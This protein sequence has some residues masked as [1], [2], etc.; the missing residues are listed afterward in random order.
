MFTRNNNFYLSTSYFCQTS[1]DQRTFALQDGYMSSLV[2]R[3]WR[4]FW[5][6]WIFRCWVLRRYCRSGWISWWNTEIEMT[7]WPNMTTKYVQDLWFSPGGWRSSRSSWIWWSTCC[8][9]S[10]R[11][12]RSAKRG[13][14]SFV[15]T[16]WFWDIDTT[17]TR[18]IN[19]HGSKIV[20]ICLINDLKV[21]TEFI[22][23]CSISYAWS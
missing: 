12:F 17:W 15:L 1:M 18:N 13:W 5:G 21:W 19:F 20:Q 11:W 4:I 23:I 22:M 7:F 14:Y 6:S 8:W 16:E 10:I 2:F 3:N 9:C